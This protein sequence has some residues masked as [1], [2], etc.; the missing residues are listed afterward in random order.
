MKFDLF[1]KRLAAL[2]A[3]ARKGAITLS[4]GTTWK[5]K[6]SP[7]ETLVTLMEADED[8]SK[9]TPEIRAE[10]EK[11]AKYESKPEDRALRGFVATMAREVLK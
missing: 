3:E 10:G 9:L 4:D 5:P 8:P 1:R 11:W 7:I 2:E 6:I